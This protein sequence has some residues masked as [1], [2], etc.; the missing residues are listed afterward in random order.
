MVKALVITEIIDFNKKLTNELREHNLNISIDAISTNKDETVEILEDF[1]PDII[2]ID[3]RDMQPY[4]I[5]V[6]ANYTEITI[7]LIYSPSRRLIRS[8]DLDLINGIIKLNDI[9]RVKLMI[10]KELEYI[11]Y[12]FKYKGTHYLA[13]AI[14]ETYLQQYVQHDTMTDNLQ[15]NVYPL[16]AKKYNKTIYNVKS[17]IGK[18]TDCMYCDCNME[19]LND[20]FQFNYDFKP[21]PK[22]VLFTVINRILR[23]S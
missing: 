14:L 13:D 3:R 17:S 9:E 11:G 19:R 4:S 8:T 1:S 7:P 5:G 21:T 16:I 10:V 22:Q 6:L 18:A 12:Q 2:F 23:S 15:T 20:Y